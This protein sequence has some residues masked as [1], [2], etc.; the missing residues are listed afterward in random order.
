MG[1]FR[2]WP[3]RSLLVLALVG[4]LLGSSPVQ[5][6]ARF[7]KLDLYREGRARARAGDFA[8][9]AAIFSDVISAEPGAHTLQ[10]AVLCDRMA[11]ARFIDAPESEEGFYFIPFEVEGRDCY[12]ALWGTF[13]TE[14]AALRG[15]SA[16]PAEMA[17][18]GSKPMSLPVARL[19]ARPTPPPPG[20][21]PPPPAA[22]AA[23]RSTTPSPA[24]S[25]PPTRRPVRRPKVFTNDA[26]NSYKKQRE[27]EEAK[28]G[29]PQPLFEETPID[30]SPNAPPPEPPA[31]E[32]GREAEPSAGSQDGY[33]KTLADNAKEIVAEKEAAL[34]EAKQSGDPEAIEA[35]ERDL[36]RARDALALLKEKAVGEGADPGLF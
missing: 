14:S 20:P 36:G 15:V 27:A 31:E 16:L 19:L 1:G 13:P 25:P 28:Y 12:K 7:Q 9:A 33:W 5:A 17:V 22:A 4:W 26:L 8:G 23:P 2:Q 21:P 24:V 10:L 29:V 3:V 6:A 30:T 32:I 11:V 18:E 35:A 34:A